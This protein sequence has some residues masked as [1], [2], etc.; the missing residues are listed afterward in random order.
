MILETYQTKKKKYPDYGY[1]PPVPPPVLGPH[2]NN[3][4]VGYTTEQEKRRATQFGITPDE[5]KRRDTIV[6]RLFAE[7]PFRIGQTVKPVMEQSVA[8]YGMVLIRG[9]FRSY[10]DF[11]TA[12][13]KAW[14]KDD[15]PYIITVEPQMGDAELLLVTTK[16]LQK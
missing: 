4:G 8:Q 2:N 10:H 5:F 14:P 12:E 13:A 15:I 11:P 3:C 16:F 6:R 1:K 9:I 7:C